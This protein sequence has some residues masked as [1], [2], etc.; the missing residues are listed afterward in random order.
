MTLMNRF[1]ASKGN[2]IEY[3]GELI[4]W[5]AYLPVQQGDIVQIGFRSFD[6]FPIQGLVVCRSNCQAQ[7]LQI[8]APT[9]AKQFVF[10]T[11]TAPRCID[12]E[13]LQ[14]KANAQLEFF[15]VWTDQTDGAMLYRLN[16]AAMRIEQH[17]SMSMSMTLHC[18]D[19]YGLEE[20]TFIDLII[21]IEIKRSVAV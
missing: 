18:N 6:S 14:A 13:I 16:N 2:P 19:G 1:M 20:P 9:E 7:I 15:N 21:D 10:W 17:S 12:I 4:H 3:H 5:T 8:K 11:N